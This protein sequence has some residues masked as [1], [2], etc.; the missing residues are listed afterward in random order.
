[1]VGVLTLISIEVP[2]IIEANVFEEDNGALVFVDKSNCPF[3]PQRMFCVRAGGG[4]VRGHH[5]HRQ[6]QQ[7]LFVIQGQVV[8]S[9]ESPDGVERRFELSDWTKGLYLPAMTWAEQK[10]LSEIAILAVVCARP[11][12]EF[13]YIRSLDDYRHIVFKDHKSKSDV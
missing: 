9:T 10:Y 6:D 11:Y 5:A 8:V 1:M 3:I 7:F 2:R 13:D 4:Q 12:D